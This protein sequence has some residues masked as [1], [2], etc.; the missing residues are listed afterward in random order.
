[1]LKPYTLNSKFLVRTPYS[2]LFD[3]KMQFEG[4]F[5]DN[6]LNFF[7]K[8][9]IAKQA[10][11]L[12]STNFYELIAAIEKEDLNERT[13]VTLAKYSSR[14]CSR[15]I[16]FGFFSGVNVGV[17]N[18]DMNKIEIVRNKNSIKKKFLRLDSN[19]TF[20]LISNI[21]KDETTLTKL[22]YY[23]NRT[24]YKLNGTYRY[25]EYDYNE[26]GNRNY[27]I[28][29][30]KN[31]N[32][33][34]KLIHLAKKGISFKKIEDYFVNLGAEIKDIPLIVKK[35]IDNQLFFPNIYP[36]VSNS[37][38][39]EKIFKLCEEEDIDKYQ[40]STLNEL[41]KKYNNGEADSFTSLYNL[42]K[43]AKEKSKNCQHYFQIDYTTNYSKYELSKNIKNKIE[44]TIN[45]LS[46][47]PGY[48]S[49][50]LNSFINKFKFKYGRNSISLCEALDPDEGL[51]Y[52]INDYNSNSELGSLLA[53]IHFPSKSQATNFIKWNWFDQIILRKYINFLNNSS[54]TSLEFAIDDIPFEQ[55]SKDKNKNPKVVTT[56][57]QFINI[58]NN[59]PILRYK[60][61]GGNSLHHLIG[62][63]TYMDSEI[64]DLLKG[65]QKLDSDFIE[66]EILN[67]P[68]DRLGNVIQH[69]PVFD[70]EI[71][72]FS[73]TSVEDSNV[74][75]LE[76]LF[77]KIE[78][79]KLIIFSNK[80]NKKVIP[81]LCNAHVYNNVSLPAY[82]FLC[83]YEHYLNNT[84]SYFFKW[85]Q[86]LE[87]E[88]FLPRV[89]FKGG[90]ISKA[91]WLILYDQIS[92][93]HKNKDYHGMKLWR[94]SKNIPQ[95]VFYLEGDKELLLNL[96]ENIHLQ[97]LFSILKKFNNLVLYESFIDDNMHNIDSNS[98][99]NELVLT[100]RINETSK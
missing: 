49:D 25:I 61:L 40:L 17:F 82:S 1:M 20:N 80:L 50:S 53:K 97:I 4:D 47:L 36:S 42:Q 100:F 87:S 65:V 30:I 48:N 10:I 69:P 66:A 92:N 12:S 71:P 32:G 45:F 5:K 33:L 75:L 21:L 11:F 99:L 51:G 76:D 6:L 56:L 91:R 37:H 29:K 9:D 72:I 8:N 55:R 78:D 64:L 22:D 98:Y 95:Y 93:L 59:E 2:S 60:A 39:F 68:E 41:I 3:L 52:P 77:L 23:P 27:K 54:T 44:S 24:L 16:P 18:N 28:T 34:Y 7:K 38:S 84:T 67:F 89:T 83:D 13:L 14:F 73:T 79:D 86:I 63:Y 26:L 43:E 70:Y 31:S 81:R 96:N 57:I 88:E 74:I 62:R 19:F 94:K 90:V 58:D 46:L 15:A 35:L 85:P